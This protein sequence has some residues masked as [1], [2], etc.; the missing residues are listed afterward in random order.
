MSKLLSKVDERTVLLASIVESSDDAIIGKTP[1]GIITSWNQGAELMYGYSAAEM[2][3]Q[4]IS[5]IIPA[6]R[7]DDM[8]GILTRIRQGERVEHYET[9]RVS[10]DGKTICTS[11]TVSPIHDARGRLIGVSSIAR[12]VTE[13][14]RVE[15]S[16]HSATQSVDARTALLASIVDSSDDAVIAKT[17]DGTITSW[18]RGAELIYGY[19]AAEIIGKPITMVLNP[20]RPNE[21]NEILARIRNGERVEHYETMR[22]RKDGTPISISLTVSPI[23]DPERR[24]IGVSSIARDVTERKRV[25]ES[26]RHATQSVDARTALLASIVDSSDDAIIAKTTDGTITS[27]NRGAELIY[28]YTAVEIIGKPITMV[29]N[30]DRPNE[31]NEILARIRNGERVEHYETMRARKDG[32]P[33]FISL[34]VSPICDSEHKLIGVSSIARDV[35]ERKR[36]EESLRHATQSVDARTALLASIVDSSDDAI[37]AKTTDGTITSWNRGAELIY[38]YTAAEIIGKPITMVLNPD[39]PNEMHDILARIR[40]GE[41][42]EHY[43]T[44]R[45]RKDGKPISISLTVSPIYD[46]DHKLIGVSSIARD[47]TERKRADESLRAASLYSRSLIEASLDPLV[48][49][50]PEGKI[51]DVNEATIKVT[52]VDRE[53]LIGTDFSD[54]FTEPGQ[55]REG[56]QQVFS[57]GSVTDYPLTIRHRDGNVKDVL[58]NASVYR[59][60]QGEV[61][62][63]FA[64]ARDVT[65]QKQASQYA[66][67]LIEAS[68]DP[69]VT[70]SPEGKIT[71]VNEATIKITG[72]ERERLIGADFSDYFIEPDKAREGYQRVFA[73]GF[74]TDYPLTI[75]HKNGQLTDVLYNASVYKDARGN[76]L[77]VFAAAR[78]VT[79]QQQA[80]QYARSLIEA[81]LDP[82][83]TIS[84]EGK[85]TDVNAA[86]V[87]VTGVSREKLI[88]TDF[89]DYFTVPEK[90]REGY[91][92]VFS[93]GSVTDYPLTI[94]HKDSR[95]TDVLYNASVYKDARGNVRGVFAAA[96]DVT[97]QKQASQYARSLVEASLDPL[98]TISPEGKITDVNEATIKATGV[99]RER[100][101]GADFS[102]Y[103]TEPDKARA[104]Y[105]QVFSQGFVTDYPLT[106]RHKD[107]RVTDVLYNASVYKDVRGNVLGV[108]AAARDVTAQKKAEA[109][110]AEQRT[111]ELE[112]LA[113]LERFQK[114]TVGRELKMI[115]LK[116]EI[117]DLKMKLPTP[118]VESRQ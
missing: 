94:R 83:V 46:S 93:Q 34:T 110:V 1:E 27:W 48:T 98:V 104:G 51:T 41:R 76:V 39:R 29:L 109:E 58:Y 25:E 7:P 36:V 84:P 19:T 95:V 57:R 33:I 64:A 38:G 32:T 2:V 96:R 91:R 66:R 5:A 3:G 61:L 50:S 97:A 62:G 114:L 4:P 77:G 100:L 53:G 80:S 118:A 43:E 78:D 60:A 13:R 20:D 44:M 113:E 16:A 40:N 18:N 107:G 17:T 47:I 99:E 73:E 108:F 6:D 71:D 26:L 30:P 85:I 10:R 79:A 92:Q 117:S 42:V 106:I 21:M 22:A 55:A 112:R 12:D 49:I 81:S 115:E 102:D 69:L 111:K 56:Y 28:G 70:I 105:R 45:S 11:L 86:L 63:V 67:S 103:F 14:K 15:A 89:S 87:E 24:L 23:Y 59:D 90:A 54:Y 68:L 82:L 37:I 116:K 52:G 72:S 88:G 65:A 101:I 8:L 35:T 75:R 74:V 31:M 9:L